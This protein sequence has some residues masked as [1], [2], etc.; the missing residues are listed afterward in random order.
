M[1][2]LSGWAGIL[3]FNCIQDVWWENKR[4]KNK[5]SKKKKKAESSDEETEKLLEKV[6]LD[7]KG[8]EIPSSFFHPVTDYP[9]HHYPS[10]PADPEK[11]DIRF[12]RP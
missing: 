7:T 10:V 1:T 8:G 2:L 5:A 11:H 4:K 12:H 3:L 6:P 9:G